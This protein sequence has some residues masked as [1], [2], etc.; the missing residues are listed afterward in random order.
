VTDPV[1]AEGSLSPPGEAA[2]P[3]D[4]VRLAESIRAA[5]LATPGVAAM[6]GGRL[7]EAATYW[8]NR[9]VM[10]VVI[11]PDAIEVHI[12]VR[13]P[14]GLPAAELDRR[15]RVRLEPIALGRRMDI[16][17]EDLAIPDETL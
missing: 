10:G 1:G 7:V 6:G 15:L 17:F 14:E 5:V 9:K 4:D 13:Y 2:D 16:V 3:E 12:V 8:V 11:H